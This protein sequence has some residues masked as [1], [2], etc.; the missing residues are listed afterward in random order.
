MMAKLK[1]LVAMFICGVTTFSIQQPPI[2]ISP[3]SHNDITRH[4]MGM[5]WASFEKS[6]SKVMVA[7]GI[8]K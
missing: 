2:Q 1:N 4:A 5:T 7:E 6:L 3:T 8:E